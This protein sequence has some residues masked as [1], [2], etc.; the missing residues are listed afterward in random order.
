MIDTKN[1]R[2]IKLTSDTTFKYLYKDEESREWIN[3]II[4]QKFNLDL[5]D[6]K[7]V[8]NELNTGN[9]IKDYR[10]DLKLEKDNS[11]VIIEMNQDYYDFLDEKNYQ[12]FAVNRIG[13]IGDSGLCTG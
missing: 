3:N 12:Y 13:F 9:R 5:N 6:Y 10:L 2:F 1:L 8:D 11:V 7:I 4:K